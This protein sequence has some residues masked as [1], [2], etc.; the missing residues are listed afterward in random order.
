MRSARG[1]L[2]L[3][4]GVSFQ[5]DEADVRG[6]DVEVR[7][8]PDSSGEG[9]FDEDF[10]FWPVLIEIEAED[11]SFL[12]GMIVLVTDLLHSLWRAGAP[13]VAACDFEDRLP[14][15]GGIRC[16][17]SDVGRGPR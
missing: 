2:P 9:T 3:E 5:E 17:S 12:P 16:G 10:L 7:R 14:W 15:S 8:N 11:D 13:A 4:P 1:L 6:I